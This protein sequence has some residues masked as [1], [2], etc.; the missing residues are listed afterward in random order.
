[1]ILEHCAKTMERLLN[2]M[3]LSWTFICITASI[4]ISLARID[5]AVNEKDSKSTKSFVSR[6]VDP[7]SSEISSVSESAQRLSDQIPEEHL[8]LQLLNASE[9]ADHQEK[10]T[11]SEGVEQQSNDTDEHNCS[12]AVGNTTSLAEGIVTI[13]PETEGVILWIDATYKAIDLGMNVS[14]LAECAPWREFWNN[15][16]TNETVSSTS[17]CAFGFACNCHLINS[18]YV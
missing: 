13:E 2:L 18:K 4:S 6:A 17:I 7:R 3:P 10:N 9:I 11:V 15:S 1:M 5:V 12:E 16:Q 14:S 8:M